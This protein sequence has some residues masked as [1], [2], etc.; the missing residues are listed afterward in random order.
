MHN[1][2]TDTLGWN[3]HQYLL[4][5]NP[6]FQTVALDNCGSGRSCNRRGSNRGNVLTS[7]EL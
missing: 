1:A 6:D 7:G 5:S 3:E 2:I 4:S